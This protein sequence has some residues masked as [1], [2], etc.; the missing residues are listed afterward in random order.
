VRDVASTALTQTGAVIGTLYYMSPEQCGGE[1]LDARADVYSLGAMFYE[2]LTGDPPF[3]SR[4]LAGLISKHLHEQA[5]PFPESLG[6]PRA[7]ELVCLR[8]LAKDRNQRPPDAIAF[9]REIQNGL[10]AP[11]IAYQPSSFAVLSR[12]SPLKWVLVASGLFIALVVIIGAGVAIKFGMDRLESPPATSPPVTSPSNQPVETVS[13]SDVD[14]RGTWSG[15][16]GPL[17]YPTRLIIRNQN[18]DKLDGTLEQG[19][20]RVAFTGTYDSGAKTLTMKQTK[21]LSGEGWSLGEDSGT[22]S[23]DGNKISGTGKDAL[24]GAL[25]FEYQWSF[26]R[27]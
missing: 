13:T 18:G 16:Y 17:G 6:I 10:T 2:M 12:R 23:D 7:L 19:A 20:F 24:G 9:G 11:P 25:G 15:T 14:L 4:S 8:A 26:T 21:V 3:R 22:L 27:R 1:E 5:A